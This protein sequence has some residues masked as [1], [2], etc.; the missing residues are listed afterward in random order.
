M[1]EFHGELDEL[2][3]CRAR[4]GEV[5]L[6][7]YRKTSLKAAEIRAIAEKNLLEEYRQLKEKRSGYLFSM[8]REWEADLGEVTD[9]LRNI[10]EK[11][12]HPL[13]PFT[14]VESI[15]RS[16]WLIYDLARRYLV[17]R[18]NELKVYDNRLFEILHAL[19]LAH[20]SL[21]ENI[22]QAVFQKYRLHHYVVVE[23]LINAG[24]EGLMKSIENADP[25]VGRLCDYASKHIGAAML[26]EVEKFGVKNAIWKRMKQVKA[27]HDALTEK[28]KQ[29]PGLKDIAERLGM[30]ISKV[31]EA[32]CRDTR[33][34]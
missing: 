33:L 24:N 1:G 3:L 20:Q 11:H 32:L 17:V 34:L 31:K 8:A 26:R 5:M 10:F 28:A 29:R 30:T 22:A 4:Q 9:D 14:K 23:D 7:S 18:Q 27:E 19:T 25:K 16:R 6:L 15:E 2:A 21:V 13:S 12:G